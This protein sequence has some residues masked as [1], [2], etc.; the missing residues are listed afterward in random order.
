MPSLYFVEGAPYVLVNIVSVAMYKSLGVSN[1]EIAFWTSWLGLIWAFKA[2]WSPLVDGVW[3]KR[4]WTLAMQALMVPLLIGVA[5]ALPLPGFVQVTLVLF[6]LLGV[7]SATH[8]IAADGLYMLGLTEGLQS[9]FVGIRSTFWRVALV[10]S[11]GGLVV[12]AGVLGQQLGLVEG[13]TAALCIAAA[14]IGVGA[15]YHFLVLPRPAQDAPRV[16]GQALATTSRTFGSFF[17]KDGLVAGLLFLVYFRF[18]ENHMAK[19]VS[20]FLLDDRELGGL[21]M[22]L[23]QLGVAKGTVGVVCLVAGG[24][25]GG[26]AIYRSGLRAWLWPMVLA[27]NVPDVIYVYLAAVQPERIGWITALIGVESF[28]YGFGFAAYLMFM[29]RLAQGEFK[30]AHYAFGTG[31]MALAAWAAQFWSGAAQEALGYLGF[32]T[33]VCLLTI[34]GVWVATLVDL[35]ADFGKGE[36]TDGEGMGTSGQLSRAPYLTGV[37]LNAGLGAGIAALGLATGQG[38]ASSVVLGGLLIA[39]LGPALTVSLMVY[40]MWAALPSDLA[41]LPPGRAAGLLLVPGVH[42]YWVFRALPPFAH[43]YNVWAARTGAAPLL[44]RGFTAYAVLTVLT[45]IP[46]VGALAAVA[47]LAVAGWLV[48]VGIGAVNALR[49]SREGYSAEA[50]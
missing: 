7:V 35:P 46:Y 1:T 20:P 4:A 43:A 39:G 16:G 34:P 47:N 10:T 45:V 33:W 15:I 9:A 17:A 40:R 12:L 49:A 42:L 26:L 22:S 25:L 2:L 48:W 36:E 29:I 24:I 18:A 6:A 38:L 21:G 44:V 41:S 50:G 27:L 5:L 37:F 31:V 8:D 14:V 28:G 23:S 11:E 32:F 19:L 30:T 3:T 13:W